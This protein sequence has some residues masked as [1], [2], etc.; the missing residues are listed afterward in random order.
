MIKNPFGHEACTLYVRGGDGDGNGY[1]ENCSAYYGTKRAER[2]QPD[3][4]FLNII[5]YDDYSLW[6]ERISI[7][8]RYAIRGGLSSGLSSLSSTYSRHI[9]NYERSSN[10]AQHSG[11]NPSLKS[12]VEK[13]CITF[14]LFLWDIP[15]DI[16]PEK[17][18]STR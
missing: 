4:D 13:L 5:A 15:W 2:L 1:C 11:L 8:D 3:A 16:S 7:G 10:T 9:R 17:V 14:P 6:S 18:S 12:N